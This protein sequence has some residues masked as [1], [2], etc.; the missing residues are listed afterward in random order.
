MRE[1]GTGYLLTSKRVRDYMEL[2]LG[3]SPEGRYN[4]YFAP[5]LAHDLS[6]QPDTL[7][8]TAQHDPLRDEGEAYAERLRAA[9]N[10]VELHRMRDALHGYF[11]LPPRFAQVKKT[12]AFINAFLGEGGCI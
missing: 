8:I 3:D 10:R 12:Y 6:G 1:N 5:L 9:G 4:P 2:Y 11:S 7:I